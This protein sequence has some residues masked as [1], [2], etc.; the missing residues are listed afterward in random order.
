MSLSPK[1]N[2]TTPFSVTDILSPLD[3]PYGT[4]AVSVVE[5]SVNHSRRE[6]HYSYA[7]MEPGSVVVASAGIHVPNLGGNLTSGSNSPPMS[8]LYRQSMSINSPSHHVSHHHQQM[9]GGMPYQGIN[10]AAAAVAAGMNGSYNLHSMGP[11]PQSAF[12]SLPGAGAA[13]GYCNTAVP[14]LPSYNNVQAATA[15]W[16]GSTSNPDPRFGTMPSKI[17]ISTA[18]LIYVKIFTCLNRQI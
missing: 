13:V 12:H 6:L 1:Q 8:S 18:I 3:D 16:Y 11:T 9:S 5:D 4:G 2:T 14:E 15:G 7:N 17:E 10:S